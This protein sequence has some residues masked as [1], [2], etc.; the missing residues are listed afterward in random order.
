MRTNQQT[1]EIKSKSTILCKNEWVSL[2]IIKDPSRKIGG[3]VYSSEVRCNGNIVSF[4]PYRY[5][6]KNKLEF[7]FRCE[8]TPCWDLDK[9]CVSSFTGGVDTGDSIQKTV[10]KELREE[11]GFEIQ[12]KDLIDLGQTYGSKSSDTIYH[13][14]SMDLSNLKQTKELEVESELEKT[15]FCKWY[16][17]DDIYTEDPLAYSILFRF[18]QKF[19]K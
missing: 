19:S 17:Y 2:N 11:S 10:L 13:L 5:S 7:L 8:A 14:F 1:N 3:Y 15:S 18:M 16:K 6:E 12:N 4:L 9:I